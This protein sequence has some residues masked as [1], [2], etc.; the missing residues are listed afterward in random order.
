MVCLTLWNCRN[1]MRVGEV[2]W[3]LNK[4]A[5]VAHRHLQEFQQV[6][7]CPSK[8]VRAQ[9]PRWK[10]LDT[11]FVKANY[12][13]AIFEDLSAAGIGVAVRNE[14]GEVV[15]ALAKQIPIP[16]SVF[17]LETLAARRAVLFVQ[18]LGLRNAVFEGDSESSIQAIS[19]RL[20]SHSSCGH[21]IHDILVFASSF[22]SFSFSH[23]CRQ[24]FSRHIGSTSS[25]IVELWG[26]REG[27]LLCCNLNIESLVVDLDAQAMVDVLKN[28][29]YANNVISPI[30]DDCRHL[31][32]RF[33]RIHFNHCYR[34]AN[35]CADLLAR[36]G[37]IQ[38]LDFISFVS[39]PAD[40]CNAFEDD[41]NGVYF[42]RMCTDP[43]V[44][45]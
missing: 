27:L 19:N 31:A 38:E 25:F 22:Q 8:K 3:P 17:T 21:I 28:N 35:Q 24:G 39:P 29:A 23:V 34:Q 33:Q 40:I 37:A 12:D 4:V 42:N 43:G 16:N 15:A 11:G 41:L 32:A 6:W 7:R 5:G 30:L 26:L 18:E 2:V 20:L 14:H 9:R 44:I 10:P 45:V 1:K 36:M 13:G